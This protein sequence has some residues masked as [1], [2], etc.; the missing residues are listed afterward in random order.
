VQRA[1]GLAGDLPAVVTHPG[2]AA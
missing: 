1:L 2:P